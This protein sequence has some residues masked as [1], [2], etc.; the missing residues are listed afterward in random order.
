MITS[1]VQRTLVKSPPELWSELSDPE[2]LA[3][4]LG[5]LGDIKIT[6]VEPENLVE[7]E[8][9]GTTGTVEI[10][11]SGWGTR[12]TLTVL[13]ELPEGVSSPDSRE[14][15]GEQAAAAE[16]GAQEAA[17]ETFEETVEAIEPVIDEPDGEIEL[18]GGEAVDVEL[19]AASAETVDVEL[20]AAGGEV[21]DVEPEPDEATAA[22]ARTAIHELPAPQKPAPATEA[23]RRAAG[24]PSAPY[25]PEGQATETPESL[26]VW[27]AQDDDL[28]LDEPEPPPAA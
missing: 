26:P 6:R 28:D 14:Q 27:G 19:G 11:A 22:E 4:H 24:W 17:E 20:E 3:R 8:A 13:R 10:K 15:A 16:A 2:A 25:E 9:D 23:A 1:E 5:E 21:V 18:D 7:W 12:V